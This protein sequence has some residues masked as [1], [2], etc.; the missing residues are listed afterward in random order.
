MS[1]FERPTFIIQDCMTIK[2]L[3]I[4]LIFRK[5][6][7]VG[8]LGQLTT[9]TI[10]ASDWKIPFNFVHLHQIVDYEITCLRISSVTK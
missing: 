10:L 1:A 5:E 4:I 7:P 3:W 2:Q 9:E 8:A 6:I